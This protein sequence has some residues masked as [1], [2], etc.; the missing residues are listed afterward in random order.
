MGGASLGQNELEVEK[1]KENIEI[2]WTFRLSRDKDWGI[3]LHY[4]LDEH[5]STFIKFSVRENAISVENL[6]SSNSRS[7]EAITVREG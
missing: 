3:I 1:M 6:R 2:F 4:G 7:G 5:E